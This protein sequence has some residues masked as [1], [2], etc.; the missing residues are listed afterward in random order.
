M[1]EA[2][3]D[4]STKQQDPRYQKLDIS[5][6]VKGMAT[7][8]S[9]QFQPPGT[10]TFA[11]NAT[12]V[13]VNGVV[14]SLSNEESNKLIASYP[15]T[16]STIPNEYEQ[17]NVDLPNAI[18]VTNSGVWNESIQMHECSCDAVER[19]YMIKYKYTEDGYIYIGVT[20]VRDNEMWQSI[21]IPEWLFDDRDIVNV[22]INLEDNSVF[23]PQFRYSTV[24]NGKSYNKRNNFVRADKIIFGIYFNSSTEVTD[25]GTLSD[26]SKSTSL[27]IL[28]QVKNNTFR[29]RFNNILTDRNQSMTARQVVDRTQY[30][31]SVEPPIENTEL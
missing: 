19:S 16:S 3:N 29:I 18:V 11:L 1:Q 7:D 12:K 20:Y 13:S 17:A 5:V 23:E 2:G 8:F 21:D 22:Y 31:H 14:N 4:K 30:T 6:P 26:G 9:H 10:Y 27:A 24:V 25:F 15:S 28:E